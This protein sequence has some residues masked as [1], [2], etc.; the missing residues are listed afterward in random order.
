MEFKLRH[1]EIRNTYLPDKIAVDARAEI[2]NDPA[3]STKRTMAGGKIR[4]PSV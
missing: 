3:S 4:L 2:T 1:N